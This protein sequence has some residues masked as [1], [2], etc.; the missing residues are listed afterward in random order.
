MRAIGPEGGG[1][2]MV[3]TA[4]LAAAVRGARSV[5]VGAY[6]LHGGPLLDALE[7]AGD[8]GAQVRVRLGVPFH[9]HKGALGRENRAVVAELRH[10]GVDAAVVKDGLF[11]LKAAVV[12]GTA[13]LDDRNWNMR[14]D[15]VVADG[16]PA[17]V[18]AVRAAL[19]GVAAA[20]APGLATEKNGALALERDVIDRSEH[21]V[22]VQTET[23][24]FGPMTRALRDAAQR[25]HV[26]L[27]VAPH[28]APGVRARRALTALAHDGVAVRIGARGA[29]NEK[30]CASDTAAW[31]HGSANALSHDRGPSPAPPTGDC[32]RSMAR[33]GRRRPRAASA[34]N[35]ELA[36]PFKPCHRFQTRDARHIATTA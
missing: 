11:H 26:R 18:A 30:L 34:R 21:G 13:Y 16:R 19:E 25:E 32:A 1:V 28:A 8:G 27:L 22:D 7:H 23:L 4:A 15:T 9:D 5:S 6:L 12:D 33:H 29:G 35:W 14:G 31:V 20:S 17:D 3:S 24:G 36:Q 2:G 10:H